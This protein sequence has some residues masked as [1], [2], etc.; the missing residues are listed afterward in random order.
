MDFFHDLNDAVHFQ[1]AI[2]GHTDYVPSFVRNYHRHTIDFFHSFFYNV[3][4]TKLCFRW[5]GFRFD[6]WSLP[7]AM[8]SSSK[9]KFKQLVAA[10][11]Y[12]YVYIDVG[13]FGITIFLF[14]SFR[15]LFLNILQALGILL[16]GTSW[17]LSHC[18]E[19]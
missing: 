5:D 13:S 6:S 2:S 10:W 17:G 15:V 19:Q 11:W 3:A 9:K 7:Q 18:S 4:S 16:I 12:F 8:F 14:L 1:I